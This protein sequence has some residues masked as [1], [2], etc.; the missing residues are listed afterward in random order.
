MAARRAKAKDGKSGKSGKA[1]DKGVAEIL[2]DLWKLLKDY[3][4][5]ECIDP[6]KSLGRFLG[7]GVPGSL[8]VG[9]GLLFLSLGM[10]RA[11]QRETGAHLTGS[12]SWVPYL[13]TLIV[14][15]VLA[16]LAIRSIGRPN[17]VRAKERQS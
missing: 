5:Q 13:V 15:A 10:L 2:A 8:L 6:L 4:K 9:L 3:A 7:Y 17:R 1:D 11:L 12:L 14:T 16:F